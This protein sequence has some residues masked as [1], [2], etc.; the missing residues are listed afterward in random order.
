[1]LPI[2]TYVFG[3]RNTLK[4]FILFYDAKLWGGWLPALPI[5]GPPLQMTP[6]LYA[7]FGRET[8]S[9]AELFGLTNIIHLPSP[10]KPILQVGKG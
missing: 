5:D 7:E 4:I 6:N 9:N 3:T 8:A 1:M 10:A 2:D